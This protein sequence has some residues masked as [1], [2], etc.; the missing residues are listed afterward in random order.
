MF[1]HAKDP[2]M[3]ARWDLDAKGLP[4]VRCGDF[5]PAVEVARRLAAEADILVFWYDGVPAASCSGAV[6]IGLASGVPVLTSPVGWFSDVREATYQPENLEAG[7]SRLM[8]DTALRNHLVDSA[9]AYCRNHSWSKTAE[10]HH[11]LWREL[12]CMKKQSS[13]N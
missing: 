8:A 5:L 4:V 3:A 10:R 2:A 12:R 6:R 1:S 13:I 11:R 9:K 7:V